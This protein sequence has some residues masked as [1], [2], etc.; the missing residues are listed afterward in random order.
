MKVY[1]LEDLDDIVGVYTSLEAA[2]V[3]AGWPAE[4][5]KPDEWLESEHQPRGY[6]VWTHESN[7]AM[8][9]ELELQREV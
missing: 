3:A 2:M 4:A 7:E 9:K 5:T 1:V 6:R 8:I